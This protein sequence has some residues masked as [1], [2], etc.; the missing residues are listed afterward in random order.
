MSAALVLLAAALLAWPPPGWV[1]ARV[2]ESEQTGAGDEAGGSPDPFD[3]A[4]GYDTLAVCLRSGLP[5]AT[6]AAVAAR[7]SPPVLGRSLTRAAELLALGSDPDQAWAAAESDSP[8]FAELAALIRR[9]SRAGSA[10]A[11]VVSGFADGTRRRAE[12]AALEAAE[13][14]GVKISGPLGLCFLPAFVCLGIAPVVIG[15]ASGLLAGV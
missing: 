15:L 5:L 7:T 14:A 2:R 10:V 13:R 3:I 6:A 4:A 8:E 1:L 12:N 11:D 9:A